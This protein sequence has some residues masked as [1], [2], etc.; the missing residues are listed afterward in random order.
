LPPEILTEFRCMCCKSQDISSGIM[1]LGKIR[2]EFG[3]RIAQGKSSQSGSEAA[4]GVASVRYL[5]AR[6]L[7]V[8][9]GY[10]R[11]RA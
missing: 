8:A 5:A 1:E 6:L 9:L 3:S 2:C 11:M 7:K 10:G 4:T